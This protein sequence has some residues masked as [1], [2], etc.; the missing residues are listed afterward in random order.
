[1]IVAYENLHSTIETEG[2][3]VGTHLQVHEEGNVLVLGL[4]RP[5]FRLEVVPVGVVDVRLL[6]GSAGKYRVGRHGSQLEVFS[7][8]FCSFK[9]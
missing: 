4:G 2:G 1:M 3:R 9:F 5:V 8:K 7:E 6:S